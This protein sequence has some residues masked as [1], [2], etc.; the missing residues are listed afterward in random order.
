MKKLIVILAAVLLAA[1]STVPVFAEEEGSLAAEEV[2]TTLFSPKGHSNFNIVIV[3]TEGGGAN[4]S[5]TTD[6]VDGK[7]GVH[8]VPA[9]N[10]GYYFD[11]WDIQGDY[12]VTGQG[13]NGELDLTVGSDVVITPL[14]AKT[15]TTEIATATAKVDDSTKSPKTGN[16]D[17]TM[18]SLIALAAL[19]MVGVGVGISVVA[20][21]K[22]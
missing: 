8:I 11:H 17:T 16:T 12:I 13:Q 5:F 2:F 9:P 3:P 21:K 7:Q 4:Y 6:V 10:S 1:F 15:G 20:V 14:F 18:V 19:L 22:K